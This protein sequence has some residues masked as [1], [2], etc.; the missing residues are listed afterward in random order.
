LAN[1]RNQQRER[2][3]MLKESGGV[4]TKDR[5]FILLLLTCAQNIY[6]N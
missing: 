6:I 2:V 3:S 1:V 4:S 5:Q